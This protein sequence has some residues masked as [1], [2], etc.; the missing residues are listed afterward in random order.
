[1]ATKHSR[2]C[3]ARLTDSLYGVFLESCIISFSLLSGLAV[4][5]EL[6]ITLKII[7]APPE[8]GQN[9]GAVKSATQLTTGT[10]TRPIDPGGSTVDPLHITALVCHYISLGI[11]ALFLLEILLKMLLTR[12]SFFV[13]FW[14]VFDAFV[15]IGAFSL[16]VVF[17]VIGQ[18]VVWEEAA[19]FVVLLR[20][21]RVFTV[22]NINAKKTKAELDQEIHI[23][24]S[25]KTKCEEK[26]S[27]LQDRLDRQQL[28]IVDLERKV[29]QTTK[30]LAEITKTHIHEK[31]KTTEVTNIPDPMCN[32]GIISNGTFRMTV[33]CETD[34]NVS[35][36][37]D[38][39]N[40]ASDDGIPPSQ[41]LD[42]GVDVMVPSVVDVTGSDGGD[43]N[44]RKTAGCP[45]VVVVQIEEASPQHGVTNVTDDTVKL[46]NDVPM[47][48]SY[49]NQMF[50]KEEEIVLRDL[51]VL[52]KHVDGTTTYR[53][54]EG[55][56]MTTL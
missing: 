19:T 46:I 37:D 40:V 32:G 26:S 48:L 24:K 5:V 2:G 21:W 38:V 35:V 15:V 16:E 1:M 25:A 30:H 52:A 11:A 41:T 27:S 18:E 49:D 22:C 17:T 10:T 55:I 20:L 12:K 8:D 51:P 3:C 6:L 45:S 23:W 28:K 36:R 50:D 33:Q 54:A 31:D 56:P 43:N 14:Q 9:N 53:S 34:E 39:V 7:Q 29:A 13:K 44:V 47:P 4:A 42:G